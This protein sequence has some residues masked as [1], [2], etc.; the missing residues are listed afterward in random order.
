M[1]QIFRRDEPFLSERMIRRNKSDKGI[2][3]KRKK[4]KVI[5]RLLKAANPDNYVAG[6][7]RNLRKVQTL[8]DEGFDEVIEDREGILQTEKVFSL[9]EMPKAHA[10][11]DSSKS[12]GKVV[13]TD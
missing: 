9:N 8:M 1:R 13:V 4:V 2:F 5:I 11:L 3:C 10:W 7:S 6:T 12:F